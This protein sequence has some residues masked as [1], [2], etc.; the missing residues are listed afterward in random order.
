MDWDWPPAATWGDTLVYMLT[1]AL[2]LFLGYRLRLA[3]PVSTRRGRAA[4][5]LC[6]GPA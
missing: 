3:R 1:L 6:G 5:G 2:L 4:A